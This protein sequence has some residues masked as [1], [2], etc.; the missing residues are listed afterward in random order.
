M[1]NACTTTRLEVDIRNKKGGK[2]QHKSFFSVFFFL[3]IFSH[4]L[5]PLIMLKRNRSDPTIPEPAKR[6]HTAPAPKDNLL[7]ISAS[8][9]FHDLKADGV[10]DREELLTHFKSDEI[11]T[12][13][14]ERLD[15]NKDGVI[16]Y[17]GK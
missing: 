11:V 7:T 17:N 9:K 14:I 1:G 2:N 4:S 3:V 16:S 6:I 10:I 15:K 8:F 13:I 5:G 12:G